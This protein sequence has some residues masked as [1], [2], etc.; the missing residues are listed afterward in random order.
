MSRITNI[1]ANAGP[2]TAAQQP[3][4][5]ASYGGLNGLLTDIPSWVSSSPYIPMNGIAF[6]MEAPLGFADLNDPADR[7]RA[8]KNITEVRATSW[9]GLDLGLTVEVGEREAGPTRVLQ[10]ATKT[11]R[12]PVAPSMTV[13]DVGG[14][15]ISQFFTDWIE[16]LMPNPDTTVVGTVT[17]GLLT[18]EQI[19]LDYDS[20]S[21][22]FVEPDPTMTKAVRA[23][24]VF[25]MRPT[26]NG[27]Q[28][29]MI[30]QDAKEAKQLTIEFTG[31][32]ETGDQVKALGTT[33]LATLN[34]TNAN[35][36]GRVSHLA[37]AST[38]QGN[39][40]ISSSTSGFVEQLAAVSQVTA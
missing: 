18:Q 17:S 38:R 5:D 11:V 3:M 20:C 19:L 4:V 26:S 15:Y 28:N 9:D 35:P 27:E 14:G 30:N 24:L 34:L 39:A 7:T 10:Y 21:I 37:D 2:A 29:I 12:A 8:L 36:N 40:N 16:Q 13:W 1:T 33:M 6:L 23:V 32:P 22:L 31:T 25:N